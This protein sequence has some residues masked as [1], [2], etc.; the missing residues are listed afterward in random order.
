M[1]DA[2][3]AAAWEISAQPG[4]LSGDTHSLEATDVCFSTQVTH[5]PNTFEKLLKITALQQMSII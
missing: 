2:V 3:D 1:D 5:S 4:G